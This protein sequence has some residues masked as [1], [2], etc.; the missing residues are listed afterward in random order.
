M[1]RKTVNNKITQV[2]R[3]PKTNITRKTMSIRF[4][5]IFSSAASA[6]TIKAA[7]I[8]AS[9]MP[10]KISKP[11][12]SRTSMIENRYALIRVSEANPFVRINIQTQKDN[13]EEYVFQR[14][15]DLSVLIFDKSIVFSQPG[16]KGKF[17]PAKILFSMR[18]EN[19][20]SNTNSCPVDWSAKVLANEDHLKEQTP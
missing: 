14:R 20:P 3:N 16:T 2:D 9:R 6:K 19:H 18:R 15:K 1:I 17:P 12:V 11:Y 8:I 10:Q 13:Q 5:V 4:L 7:K